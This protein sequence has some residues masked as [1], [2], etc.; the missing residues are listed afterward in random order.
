MEKVRISILGPGK[1]ANRFFKGQAN[2]VDYYSV[3]G[4]NLDKCKDFAEKYNISKYYSIEGCLNDPNVDAVY[5]ATPNP[6]HFELAKKCLLKR[7]HVLCE[8]P[9]VATK[10]QI[11][12]LF[13]IAKENNLLIM[14]ACKQVFLPLTQKV[15]ELINTKFIGDVKYMT[16]YYCDNREGM[17]IF[18]K[19][20]W[21]FEEST[22]GAIRDIG[23]YPI[24][25]FNYLND[26]KIININSTYRNIFG[27]DGFTNTTIQYENGVIVNAVS[28]FDIDLPKC[29]D[30]YGTKGRI[31][32]DNFWK[33][34]KV[35]IY[36][37]NGEIIE[38]NEEMI[39]DF[40]YE[41]EHFANCILNNIYESPIIGRNQSLTLV[42]IYNSVKEKA[43]D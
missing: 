14:E 24:A 30:I 5:I 39:S 29:C 7:K 6:T 18:E 32:I 33:T 35:T 40:K 19:D 8:K 16:G 10:E 43:L 23:I 4:R 17:S 42:D 41:T 31:H 38:L 3:C 2:N 9:F 26:S 13:D 15:K 34:G 22:G 25:Y 28:G 20:H 36:L 37:N 27:V 21:V 11:N 12:E 1:I